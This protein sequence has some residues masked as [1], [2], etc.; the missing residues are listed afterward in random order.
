MNASTNGKPNEST[1]MRKGLRVSS[2]VHRACNA[3]RRAKM[4]CEGPIDGPC[5]RC[6][7][8][9]Q[10]CI[11]DKPR[12]ES[13]RKP[14][15]R[16]SFDAILER[17]HTLEHELQA[18]KCNLPRSGTQMKRMHSN[19][20]TPVQVR[21]PNV[22]AIDSVT[23]KES[24]SSLRP[25]NTTFL[26]DTIP[27]IFQPPTPIK[28]TSL[29]TFIANSFAPVPS[30]SSY[31]PS[32]DATD[33]SYPFSPQTYVRAK[34]K[35]L[36]NL[37][38][39]RNVQESE[40]P[41]PLPIMPSRLWS[42]V[43]SDESM[44][45]QMNQDTEMSSPAS[46][47]IHQALHDQVPQSQ[48]TIES[49]TAS[50]QAS[51]LTTMAEVMEAVLQNT[52]TMNVQRLLNAPIYSAPIPDAI[53]SRTAPIM[54]PIQCETYEQTTPCDS[55]VLFPPIYTSDGPSML[56][57]PM[58]A[59]QGEAINRQTMECAPTFSRTVHQRSEG[60]QVTYDGYFDNGNS[61]AR[62]SRPS[63]GHS[64]MSSSINGNVSRVPQPVT[65]RDN[66]MMQPGTIITHQP[67]FHS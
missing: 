39:M 67:F 10:D 50:S 40:L 61:I 30:S 32:F 20:G 26:Q 64:Q 62:F 6:Q 59:F 54:P 34:S 33:T 55:A 37:E 60:F 52:D 22:P 66:L 51:L 58:T 36:S 38:D 4:R 8:A 43:K 45:V 29:P 57:K 19:A 18:I 2:R 27:P 21:N 49:H 24:C 23:G 5:N 41:P 25:S 44:G 48:Q 15:S 53:P 35:S 14:V 1:P 56:L 17:V 16:E 63:T 3:C 65:L 13:K 31:I 9:N 12:Q 42:K 28:T 7:L 47:T 11:F 46:P